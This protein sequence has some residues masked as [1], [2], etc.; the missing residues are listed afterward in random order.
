MMNT[1]KKSHNGS[2]LSERTGFGR[3]RNPILHANSETDRNRDRTLTFISHKSIQKNNLKNRGQYEQSQQEEQEQTRKGGGYPTSKFVGTTNSSNSSYYEQVMIDKAQ[4]MNHSRYSQLQSDMQKDIERTIMAR[5][6]DKAVNRNQRTN[7]SG[8]LIDLVNQVVLEEKSRDTENSVV[9][10]SSQIFGR[11]SEDE[12]Y[13]SGTD[14]GEHGIENKRRSSIE[15]QKIL[16]YDSEKSDSKEEEE[17]RTERKV[18]FFSRLRQRF[19]TS[20][21]NRK[22]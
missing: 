8:L 12:E 9:L 1:N 14:T 4:K 22:V 16:D 15:S 21:K 19:G 3:I 18:G 20:R 5:Q 10:R 11:I 13:E 17:S 6:Y 7:N 2:R